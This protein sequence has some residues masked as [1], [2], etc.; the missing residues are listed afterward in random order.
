M[1]K[2]FL[3]LSALL[4]SLDVGTSPAMGGGLMVATGDGIQSD[5]RINA[6]IKTETVRALGEEQLIPDSSGATFDYQRERPSINDANARAPF[7][8]KSSQI[9]E[10]RELDSN[11]DAHVRAQNYGRAQKSI[12]PEALINA[13]LAEEELI[14]RNN[15]KFYGAEVDALQRSF[16]ENLKK[17]GIREHYDL[18]KLSS[19]TNSAR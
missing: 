19:E 4:L 5:P 8:Y 7:D 11:E 1:R 15:Q 13:K 9:R 14:K 2:G 16:D 6:E 17:A 18:R 12:D 3:L 10:N